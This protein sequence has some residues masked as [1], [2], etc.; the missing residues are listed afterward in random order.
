MDLSAIIIALVYVLLYLLTTVTATIIAVF[1]LWLY[2]VFENTE[3]RESHVY[4]QAK[5]HVY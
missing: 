3:L 1:G 2:Y 5:R 4:K